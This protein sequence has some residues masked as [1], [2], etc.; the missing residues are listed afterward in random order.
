M[1]FLRKLFFHLEIGRID[2]Y[3]SKSQF[4]FPLLWILPF[5]FLH[6][7]NLCKGFSDHKDQVSVLKGD[8]D[9]VTVAWYTTIPEALACILLIIRHRYI[10]ITFIF[11]LLLICSQDTNL[12]VG[13][14]FTLHQHII[15]YMA[16]FHLTGGRRTPVPLRALFQ[17]RAR[18]PE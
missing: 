18:A 1:P 16:T 14:C 13:F 3:I 5:D 7:Q 2:R 9:V 11:L 6:R 17:A 4:Q 15:G 8:R 12:F 10:P